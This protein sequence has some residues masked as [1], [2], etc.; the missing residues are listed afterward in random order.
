MQKGRGLPRP[1]YHFPHSFREPRVSQTTLSEFPVSETP[2]EHLT[3]LENLTLPEKVTLP[4]N[5][6][7]P[8]DLTRLGF[9]P[10]LAAVISPDEFRAETERAWNCVLQELKGEKPTNN[11]GPLTLNVLA[12]PATLSPSPIPTGEGR[13]EGRDPL[14]PSPIPIASA[15]AV[16]AEAAN[17]DKAAEGRPA[18][19]SPRLS[20]P[21]SVESGEGSS[22]ATAATAPTAELDTLSP[23]DPATP[24]P[25]PMGEGRGGA[26]FPTLTGSPSSPRPNSTRASSRPAT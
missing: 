13:G 7:S 14:S 3:P 8:E 18:T 15:P 6:P 12:R 22:S 9:S 25:I 2:P 24:S 4:E 17:A 11:G 21:K 5:R 1:R 16:S 19:S 20:S 10:E 23:T 26:A